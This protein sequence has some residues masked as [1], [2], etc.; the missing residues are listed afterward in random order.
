[1][2]HDNRIFWPVHRLAY[3]NSIRHVWTRCRR[4]ATKTVK[5]IYKTGKNVKADYKSAF[6]TV[7]SFLYYCY[8]SITRYKTYSYDFKDAKMNILMT[9]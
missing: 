6:L 9:Y 1:L 5:K 2:P 8:L 3:P 4:L 7:Y